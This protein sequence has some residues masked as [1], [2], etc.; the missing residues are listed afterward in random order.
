MFNIKRQTFLYNCFSGTLIYNFTKLKKEIFLKKK[1]MF[2]EVT[3]VCGGCS[4]SCAGYGNDE[5]NL[6][7]KRH[8]KTSEFSFYKN[9]QISFQCTQTYKSHFWTERRNVDNSPNNQKYCTII[10]NKQFL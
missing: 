10:Y 8:D 4:T 1:K 7:S 6:R 3:S 5:M 9:T 2:S